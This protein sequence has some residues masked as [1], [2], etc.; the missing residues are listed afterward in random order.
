VANDAVF[1]SQGIANKGMQVW[2]QKKSE[3]KRL[4]VKELQKGKKM[5]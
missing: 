4:A 2:F 3:E 1:R 5:V